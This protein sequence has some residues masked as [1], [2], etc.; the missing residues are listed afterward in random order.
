VT[1]TVTDAG[2]LLDDDVTTATINARP[3][4]VPGGPYL[5][6]F[7]E[8]IQF[9][10]TGSFDPEG[11]PIS[12]VWEFGDGGT[13]TGPMPVHAYQSG[14]DFTVTLSVTDPQLLTGEAFTIATSVPPD[15]V[16]IGDIDGCLSQADSCRTVAFTFE[17]LSTTPA[18]GASVT[19]RL[20]PE[21]Q[22]CH[23]NPN[24]DIQ[25]GSWLQDYLP[26]VLFAVESNSDGSYTVD[27]AILGDP[28][29]VTTGGQLFSISIRR[30]AGV[31]DSVGTIER[32]CG[33]NY[34]FYGLFSEIFP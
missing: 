26:S 7:G 12:Y 16:L 13:A 1:L 23:G 8:P 32:N 9:D 20:S 10:G 6:D 31:A 5:A 24:L 11:D 19:F 34:N 14:G 17:R 22:L 33:I 30:A 4:A 18:R 15:T 3:V 25:M 21:L 2:G 29:G 27:Q 28:C